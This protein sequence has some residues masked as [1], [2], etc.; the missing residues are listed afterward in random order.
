MNETGACSL[1]VDVEAFLTTT[2]MQP[3]TFGK[4]ALGD[5]QLVFELRR[6]RDPRGRTR[7]RIEAFIKKHTPAPRV[8]QRRLVMVEWHDSRRPI[9][10]WSRVGD[11]PEFAHTVC[12]SVGWLVHDGADV[13][14]IAPNLGD[15]G[16]DEEQMIG[17]IQIPARAIVSMRDLVEAP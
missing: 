11:K 9:D 2:G 6:G 14:A 16:T 8:R 15:M 7:Q 4:K 3:T 10:V 13:K 5:P 1:L 17:A 12:R